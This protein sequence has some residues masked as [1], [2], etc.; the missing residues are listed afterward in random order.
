MDFVTILGAAVF[1]GIFAGIIMFAAK[2]S[3][4]KL[5]E[6]VSSLT[7]EERNYLIHTEYQK[8]PDSDIA[9][10]APALVYSVKE[11]GNGAA[12]YLIFCNTY[13]P[14][15]EGELAP[16]DINISAKEYA[17]HPVKK[18]DRVYI[19]LNGDKS[20]K[21]AWNVSAES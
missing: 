4:E 15:S 5:N 11:K 6:A 8:A 10:Y 2:K 17:E 9:A 19:L 7:E 16:A 1:V 3:N 14:N 21:V 20:A 18:G 12:L 13:F